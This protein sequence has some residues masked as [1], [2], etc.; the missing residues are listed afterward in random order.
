MVPLLGEKAGA[1]LVIMLQNGRIQNF[2]F[3]QAKLHWSC[4]KT[5]VFIQ[6]FE[7]H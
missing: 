1:K 2:Y 3:Y 5:F 6:E 4:I 7:K